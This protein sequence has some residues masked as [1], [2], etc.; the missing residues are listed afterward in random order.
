MTEQ[1]QWRIDRP[2]TMRSDILLKEGLLSDLSWL[3]HLPAN[4]YASQHFLITDQIVHKLY[5]EKL[6]T[7]LRAAGVAITPLVIPAGESSKS[8]AIFGQLAEQA[9]QRGLDRWSF[10]FGLGGG[11][12]NNIAGFLAST[13]YRGIGLIQ[14][15]TTL[16]AQ[17]DAAIGFKNA[18]NSS[19]AKNQIGSYYPAALI[20]V[21]P[22]V[23]VTLSSRDLSNGVTEAI[24]HALAEDDALFRLLMQD[25]EFLLSDQAARL[26]LIEQVIQLKAAGLNDN[27]RRDQADVV[28]EYGHAVGHAF[29]QLSGYTLLHGESIALGMMVMA[30]LAVATGISDGRLIEAHQN[31]LSSYGLPVSVPRSF[32]TSSVLR[33]IRHDKQY[34]GGSLR[35]G[36]LVRVGELA[37]DDGKWAIA[38]PD[39][40]LEAAIG[41]SYGEA[42]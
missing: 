5:G 3:D 32:D 28:A 41:K 27:S 31:L 23:L 26:N 38:V 9:L 8:M 33:V 10:I 42:D 14:L 30:H 35:T 39:E 12:V 36:V 18:V 34:A 19:S 4:S 22:D 6:I 2:V 11:V 7:R 17:I 24:K 29:E 37:K 25:S 40:S 16:L 13:L 15:P 21:D 1:A 20:V